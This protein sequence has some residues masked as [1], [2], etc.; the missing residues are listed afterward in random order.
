MSTGK[1]TAS[2]VEEQERF[3]DLVPAEKCHGQVLKASSGLLPS[4]IR[5]LPLLR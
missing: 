2:V 5:L 3:V 4:D 1:P